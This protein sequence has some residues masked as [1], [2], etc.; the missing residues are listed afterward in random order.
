MTAKYLDVAYDLDSPQATKD[1][2]ES[3]ADSYDD[4]LQENRYASPQRT[5]QAL[6]SCAIDTH[7]S[8]YDI[9]CGSG[10]SG[11]YLKQAGFSN[12]VGSDFS[13]PMLDKARAKNLYQ[14][15]H[16]ADLT[17]P[18]EFVHKPIQLATA[19]GVMAPGHAPSSL[20]TNVFDLLAVGGLFGFSLNDHTVADPS[21][22][23]I[24]QT[25]LEQRK[26][27]I[28]WHEYGDHLPKIKLNSHIIVIEKLRA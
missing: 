9:G 24:L 12:L 5:A 28:R 2:Y 1:L 26:I 8:V 23:A 22:F 4:E 18:F 14:A 7:A 11:A 16:L 3:W 15:L 13:A 10:V 20:I 19:V 21:Y 27:R 17:D 6:R 25:L